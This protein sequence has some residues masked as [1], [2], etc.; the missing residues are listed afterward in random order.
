[1]NKEDILLKLKDDPSFINEVKDN[2]D[3]K[4]ICLKMLKTNGAFIKYID[5]PDIDMQMQAI[6]EMPMSV[7]YID[8]LCEEAAVF[9][10][11]VS[12]NTLEYI[13]NP[14]EKVLSEAVNAK[15][16]AI[17]YIKNPSEKLKLDAVKND[18][19][20]IKYIEHPSSEVQIE[21]VKSYYLAIKYIKNPDKDTVL[22]A[23]AQDAQAINYIPSYTLSDLEDFIKVN[24]NVVKY[25]YE[26]ID[27]SIVVDVLK[28]KLKDDNLDP[29]YLKDFL[30]L[31]I[32]DMDKINFIND[33]GCA[34][35]KK[36]TVD[37][38]LEI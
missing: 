35:V 1:M 20:A 18:Y 12:W 3:Y 28:E 24:I 16:W 38:E 22:Q 5:N 13:K 36:L 6:K 2:K 26:S 10:V 37:Y 30:E 34:N 8:S 31:E 29:Q 7:K 14:S 33:Y 4:E 23:I 27:V 25:V 32:L 15:G 11:K 17:R 19:D 9:A 21:A